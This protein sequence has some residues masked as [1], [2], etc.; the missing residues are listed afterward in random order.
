MATA[1]PWTTHYGPGVPTTINPDACPTLVDLLE[2]AFGRFAR[3]DMAAYLG[4]RWTFGEVD[5]QSRHLAA[6]LQG[7]NLKPG[8][9]VAIMMPNIPHYAVAIAAVLRAGYVVV[10]VNPMYTPRELAHQLNDAGAEAII[11]L[12]NVAPTL[13]E[14][15]AQTGVRHVVLAALG[16]VFGP[17]KRRWV[18]FQARHIDRHVIDFRLPSDGSC[19][20]T[21]FKQALDEGRNMGYTRPRLQ[22]SDPAFLQYTGGTTGV[23]KGA[24][25]LH[26]NLVA[27][28]L[29]CEAWFKPELDKV[30][31][32][33]VNVAA[34]PL[35]HVFALTV[36]FFLSAR[37]GAM[38]VLIDNARDLPR[39]INTLRKF[40]ITQ[41]PAVNTLYNALVE[42]PDFA[43]LDFSRLKVCNGGG[44]AVQ[45]STAQAWQRITGV[46]IVEGYGL[47]ETSPVVTVNR[48]DNRTYNGAIGYPLPSTE[49]LL[50]DDAGTPQ[51]IG[52]PGE[53]AV[54]GPQV[55]AGYWHRPEETAKVMTADGFFRTGDIGVMDETGLI[56]IVDRKKDMILVSG[57]NVY[58]NEVEQVVNL[59]PGVSECAVIGVPDERSGEAV[60]LYVVRKDYS[61]TEDD[62]LA[63]CKE[64]LTGYKRPRHIEFRE[65]LPKSNVGKILR[66]DLR[67]EAMHEM[68][69]H[70][71][72]A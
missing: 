57:F 29:Q 45:Q 56:R 16:D 15:V 47:S 11:L 72:V 46:P 3:R 6:W 44:M 22:G 19:R 24:T 71:K 66:K 23:S 1:T 28:I 43:T 18:T 21:S 51:P 7:Q 13:Q 10:N 70:R 62:V 54:R 52:Q 67:D 39:L 25:L 64:Q 53:I 63:W 30:Q 55:M 31:G 50:L 48:L 17:I 32:Q 40:S 34:L 33:L 35:Y 14:V 5:Q 49:V 60:K 68:A 41:F 61:L 58:P 9:R 38:N 36:C 12:E 20:V 2:D 27:N 59:H 4:S 69:A 42:E 65:D 26:R 8:A 37:M